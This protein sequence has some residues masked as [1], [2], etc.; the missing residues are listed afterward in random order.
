[1]TPT[2]RSGT[3]IFGWQK[4]LEKLSATFGIVCLFDFPYNKMVTWKHDP[5]KIN[6]MEFDPFSIAPIVFFCFFSGVDTIPSP[7]G[8]LSPLEVTLKGTIS[9]GKQRLPTIRD[10]RVDQ[11]L[12]YLGDNYTHPVFFHEGNPIMG[13]NKTPPSD[14]K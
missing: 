4:S 14:W 3:T 5:Y 13:K 2:Q 7:L 1:M 10:S 12:G 8:H 9:T 11:L 6:M